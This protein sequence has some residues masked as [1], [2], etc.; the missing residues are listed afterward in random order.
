MAEAITEDLLVATALAIHKKGLF[1]KKRFF[2]LRFRGFF[3]FL[4][5]AVAVKEVLCPEKPGLHFTIFSCSFVWHAIIVFHPNHLQTVGTS[6]WLQLQPSS[7]W[8]S[9]LLWPSL[10]RLVSLLQ[11]KLMHQLGALMRIASLMQQP[12]FSLFLV[13]NCNCQKIESKILNFAIAING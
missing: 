11:L 7:L 10:M 2:K 8:P 1:P 13:S 4:S 12:L 3:I 6:S 5:I 9:S